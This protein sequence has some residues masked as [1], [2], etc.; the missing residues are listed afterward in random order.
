MEKI[1]SDFLTH[2][3][4]GIAMKIQRQKLPFACKGGL[5]VRIT[6]KG[7]EARVSRCDTRVPIEVENF[8][9]QKIFQLFFK[10]GF[11]RVSGLWDDFKRKKIFSDSLTHQSLG[12]AMKIQKQKLPFACKGGL[13][14]RIT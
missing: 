2:Q 9:S 1:F 8:L 11:L 3:S 5:P 10:T 6:W 7:T 12:I 14:V 13:S 4:L